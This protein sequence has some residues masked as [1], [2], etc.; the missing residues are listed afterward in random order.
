MTELTFDKK[1]CIKIKKWGGRRDAAAFY[2]THVTQR[3]NDWMNG[4]GKIKFHIIQ[5]ND[6][7]LQRDKANY[8]NL[9]KWDWNGG[10]EER[11]LT[12]KQ[13]VDGSEKEQSSCSNCWPWEFSE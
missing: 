6:R 11:K 3:G 5:F 12:S 10:M 4:N 13:G 1:K 7:R 8:K 2:K 9:L